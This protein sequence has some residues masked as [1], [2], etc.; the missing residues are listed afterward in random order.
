MML[1]REQVR[2][3]DRRAI[4]EYGIPGV[5]L[6]ENAGRGAADLIHAIL[7]QQSVR[8]ASPAPE[9]SARRSRPP[10]VAI[11]CGRGNNGGDG[12]VIARHLHNRGDSVQL[13][14]TASIEDLTG[15]ALINATI[16]RK[17]WLPM[18]LFNSIPAIHAE[19]HLLHSADLIVDAVLGTGFAGD[20]RSPLDAAVNAINA[21]PDSIIRVAVD[22]PSGLDCDT[23]R[24]SNATVRADHTIT[25]VAP[26]RGF[27]KEDAARWTGRVHVVDIGAPRELIPVRD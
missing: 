15:D 6:M 16:A 14:L 22:V 3:I 10:C 12:Y 27:E 5:V 13:Y 23:G 24:P 2:E 9:L 20:V 25:F 8:D 26:K 11:V 4:T 18:H 19:S 7:T 21:A 17:M 1:S